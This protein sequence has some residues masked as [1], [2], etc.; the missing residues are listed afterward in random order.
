M[1]IGDKTRPD[2][3]PA[4]P[5][6]LAESVDHALT[7]PQSRNDIE[8]SLA[9]H[10]GL[11]SQAFHL[12]FE[13]SGGGTVRCRLACELSGRQAHVEEARL[14]EKGLV[15]L[16]EDL[17]ENKVLELPDEPPSFLPDT[18]VGRLVISDG[19]VSRTFFF[20]ADPEQAKTQGRPPAPELQRVLDTIYD[21]AATVADVESARP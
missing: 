9:V 17:Q 10:G 15:R 12:D 4:G 2:L 8:I 21:L 5:S 6:R 13:A 14:D 20:A 19:Q 7:D 18:L 3:T 11:P 16:L 1:E